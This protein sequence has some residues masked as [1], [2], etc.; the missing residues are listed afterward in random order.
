MWLHE[1][2]LVLFLEKLLTTFWENFL[3]KAYH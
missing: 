1:L 2:E 3:L